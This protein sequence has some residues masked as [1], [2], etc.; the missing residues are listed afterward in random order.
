M[1]G[2]I[3]ID[4]SRWDEVMFINGYAVFMG[5]LLM[6]V[7]GLTLLVVSVHG[8]PPRRLCRQSGEERLLVSHSCHS[9]PDYQVRRSQYRFIPTPFVCCVA[10]IIAYPSC[11][12]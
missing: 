1:D 8:R 7:R 5:Y 3:N 12:F 2:P 9:H 11:V 10:C 4:D 6:G